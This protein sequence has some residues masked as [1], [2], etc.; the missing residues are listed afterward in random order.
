VTWLAPPPPAFSLTVPVRGQLFDA[1]GTTRGAPMDLGDTARTATVTALADGSF[2]VATSGNFSRV[3]GPSGFLR[4]FTRDG[5]ETA[6]QAALHEDACG[7]DGPP[8]VSALPAGGFAVAWP[9]ACAGAPQVRMRV[10]DAAGGV[11]ASS[12]MTV[13]QP[14][15]RVTVGL[16]ALSN[17]NLALAWTLGSATVRELHTLVITTRLADSPAGATTIPILPG[18]TPGQVQALPEGGFVIPWSP[19]NAGEAR[20]PVSRFSAT[21][22]PL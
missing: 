19:A 14:G 16:A 15:D 12:R 8:A 3:N 2:V 10:Y 7:I 9:Y 22:E 21:G 1:S 6:F 13:G 17:G 11:A 20:V 18:R 4:A 5:A